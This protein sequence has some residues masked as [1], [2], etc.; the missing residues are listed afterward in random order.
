MS[1]TLSANFKAASPRE[2][3][4]A[5]PF[6]SNLFS[7]V[8]IAIWIAL[9][10]RAGWLDS[11]FAWSV[12]VVYVGYDI[13]LHLLVTWQTWPLR[14]GQ[15][16]RVLPASRP[17]LGVVI[18]AYNEAAHLPA[19]LQRILVQSVAADRIVIADDG[20]NDDTA[21]V[22]YEHYGLTETGPG[23]LYPMMRWLRLTRRGKA[24]ALNAA[25][26]VI[27]TDIVVT[28]DADTFLDPGALE[29]IRN[30]FAADDRLVA[31]GGIL[32]PFCD[33]S[34]MGR[35]LEFFQT[36]EYVRNIMARF[37]WVRMRSLLL[38]SGAFA[39]FRTDA[40]REVGGFDPSCLVEDYELTHRLHRYS[41]DHQRGWRLGMVS[42]AFARTEAP[43]SLKPFLR[44]RRRWFAGFL[45]TQYWNRDMTLNGRYGWVGTR[46]LL[47]KALDTLQPIYG[48]TA[49]V[50]FVALLLLGRTEAAYAVGSIIAFKMVV[51]FI[52]TASNMALYR[53]VTGDRTRGSYAGALIA[54]LLEPFSFQVLRHLG[55]AWGWVAFLRGSNGWGI[56]ARS[57]TE[58]TVS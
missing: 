27:D 58:T 16:V 57:A 47:I 2:T 56:S 34:S 45:Q 17:T 48:L 30:A 6:M 55:A 14:R 35:V 24:Q 33:Q 13:V 46:M 42:D 20:S 5:V 1:L 29:A 12:G 21:R 38:I 15:T 39:A 54:V 37:A 8:L 50:V 52:S 28:L 44:Q 32:V 36:Y 11:V 25:L 26:D 51:D 22:L 9:T 10:L 41:H 7:V 19:T 49:F 18:A 4:R 53:R 40:L 43:S 3:P 23:T 31:A